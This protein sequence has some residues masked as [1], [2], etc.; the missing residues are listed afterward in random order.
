MHHDYL[1]PVLAGGLVAGLSALLLVPLLRPLAAHIGLLD[2]PGGRK[3]HLGSVPMVGGPAIFLAY[4]AALVLTGQF[5]LWGWG[6]LLVWTL[7]VVLGVWNDLR[8][9]PVSIRVLVQVFAIV[10][11]C[12]YAG[13]QLN[14]L[15]DLL[16]QGAQDLGWYALPLTVLGL[17]GVKN[18]INLIDGLDGLAGTQVLA[19]L[20][21][22]AWLCALAARPDLLLLI[23]ALAGAVIGFLAYNLR[24]PGR[25]ARVFLGDSGSVFLGFSLGWIAVIGSQGEGA[26]F[27]PIEAVWMI[28]LPILDTI[29]VMLSRMV[30]RRSPF[31]PGR[32]H[33]HH[34]LLATGLSVNATVLL[35]FVLA[36]LFGAVAWLGRVLGLS[37]VLLLCA[38]LAVSLVYFLMGQY[39]DLR[40]V[41]R[42]TQESA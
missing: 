4:V 36:M 5:A 19:S 14:S 39:L 21:W 20:F 30:R 40:L 17:I 1:S 16:G 15:G 29:R 2:Q 12:D 28:G 18:G 6:A 41:R 42:P 13:T 32:D 24:L 37:E 38:F 8:H 7:I 35:M 31:T 25:P 34:L 22:L 9:I 33:L 10:F 27:R 26:A 3:A 23:V 11:L